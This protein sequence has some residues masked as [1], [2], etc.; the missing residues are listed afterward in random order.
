LIVAAASFGALLGA[1]GDQ[2]VASKHAAIYFTVPSSWKV[3]HQATLDRLPKWAALI[4]NTPVFLAAATA[5]PRP[6]PSDPFSPS[7][8]PWAVSMVTL[9]TTTQ[10]QQIT[11]AGLSD[12]VVDV[13]GL[14]QDGVNV[15]ELDQPQLQV[16]GSMRG[17]I[18]SYEVGSGRNAIDYEQATWV[19]SASNKIWV[20]MGG[21]S[22]TCFQLEQ[23]TIQRIIS[24][25]Y[26]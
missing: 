21:C 15:H 11:L 18:V 14:S 24:S 25:F 23:P 19:N 6:T 13:D 20:L 22:P 2:V 17:T 16:T 12:V 3:Y 7:A 10:Q 1:C 8:Y 5:S 4:T 9:L 26:A